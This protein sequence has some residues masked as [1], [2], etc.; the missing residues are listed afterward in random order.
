MTETQE[1][2][3]NEHQ[4]RIE[5]AIR[6]VPS[7]LRPFLSLRIQL[8]SAYCIAL[9]MVLVFTGAI[10]H[11]D[12][13]NPYID[14]ITALAIFIGTLLA[15]FFTTL[16]LRPLWRVTD[17][18]QAIALGDLEQRGRLPLRLP[19]QDEV[20]RLSGSLNEMVTRLEHAEQM[21]KAAEQRF[22]R[23]FTDASHQLRTPLTSLR[24]FTDVLLRGA[25]DDPEVAQRVLKRMKSEAERMTLLINNLLTL[26]RLHDNQPLKTQYMD[27]IE[28][29]QESIEHAKK[30]ASEKSKISLIQTSPGPLGIQ[31]DKER[32][33][34]LLF[35]LLDNAIKY[36]TS[37]TADEN[38]IILELEKQERQA[39]IRVID[40]G[41]GMMPEEMVHI[42]E[43]FYR[44]QRPS[45]NGKVVVGTGLGLTIAS[46]I[47]HAHHGIITA[48]SQL[49][50]GTEF[51]V[52]LPC[53]L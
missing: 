11:W 8:V 14:G 48:D 13:T 40:K 3:S 44:G 49:H 1:Q 52:T 51:T 17:A 38:T 16:L 4:E 30:Q 50:K 42:F 2:I 18:A 47:V 25:K 29:A 39:I 7:W 31:A 20:D 9:T 15:F 27:L 26:A 21:Q 12:Y 33:K 10:F 37:V 53:I 22:Q 24:G 45:N 28:L 41:E 23:F 35:I 46:A 34:Q 5:T 19:P 6:D 36:G 32:I 43:S